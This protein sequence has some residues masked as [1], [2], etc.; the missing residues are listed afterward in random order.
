MNNFK[1]WINSG[2]PGI[3]FIASAISVSL[4]LVFGVLAMT[5][6]RGLVYFWPHSIAEIQYAESDNSPPVRLIGELH[7]VEEIPISRLRNAGVTIDTPLAVVNRHLFKTG[8][9][10]VLGSDFRWIIDPFFK[11]VTYPQALL[12]IER[13]EWGNF[14]GY[15][16]SVKEEGRVVA[17][18]EA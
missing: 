7:T 15:L 8:N 16:R 6:E 2:T 9:R 1:N 3:W 12:L 14:Y 13:F 10:D 4:L 18:G 17:E 11:S 5:V